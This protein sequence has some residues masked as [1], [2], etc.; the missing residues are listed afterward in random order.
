MST[1]YTKVTIVGGDPVVGEALE[2]LLQ[3]AGYHTRFLPEFVMDEP[4]E[5]LADSQ[6]VL[7][8]PALSAKRRKAFLEMMLSSPK[9]VNIPVLELLPA[10]GGQ[11]LHAEHIVLWPCSR[12]ELKQAIDALHGDQGRSDWA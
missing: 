12:E 11:H 2:V 5:M 10:N 8:A 4:D 7:I 3:A 6:L 1:A 9:T